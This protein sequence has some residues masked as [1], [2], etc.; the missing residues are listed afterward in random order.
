[1]ISPF[2]EFFFRGWLQSRFAMI[3]GKWRGLILANVC[4]TLWHYCAPF[5]TQSPVPLKTPLGA[6]ST[7]IV[8]LLYG[9]TF[10][11]TRNIIAPWLAHILAG[12]TFIIIGAMDFTQYQ[13]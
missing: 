8:G 1:M 9:Y 4:F 6:L 13:L 11:R 3:L 7:F 10:M 5:V 12:I 2:Q